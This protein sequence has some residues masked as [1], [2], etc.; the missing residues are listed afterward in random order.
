MKKINALFFKSLVFNF[1][2][3]VVGVLIW[4]TFLREW[5]FL[6]VIAHAHTRTYTCIHTHICMNTGIHMY[7]HMHTERHTCREEGRKGGKER[8]R[9]RERE[10]EKDCPPKGFCV[11]LEQ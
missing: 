6:F 4:N 9:G 5:V 7:A 11:C 10:R 1:L 8:G 3:K 2:K